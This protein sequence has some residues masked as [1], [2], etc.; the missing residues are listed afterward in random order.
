MKNLAE[1]MNAVNPMASCS[2]SMMSPVAFN[3]CRGA[4]C[5]E[6]TAKQSDGMVARTGE[7]LGGMWNAIT[8]PSKRPCVE[9][10]VDIAG[11]AE[12]CPHCRSLQHSETDL[13]SRRDGGWH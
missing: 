7:L 3:T 2:I 5:G 9:C 13:L 1:R 10:L 6:S 8:T 11:D 12:R 4:N